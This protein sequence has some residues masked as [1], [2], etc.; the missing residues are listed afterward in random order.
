MKT[1]FEISF[2]VS[3]ILLASCLQTNTN[4]NNSEN[5]DTAS[6]TRST[7]DTK[8][9]PLTDKAVRFLWR[10]DKYD[11][12]FKDTFNTIVIDEDLCKKL[13]EPERAALG[14]V[15][16]FIGS[17]CNW[18][19]EANDDLGNLKCKTLSSLALGYQ[20]SEQ[21]LGFLRQW[22][23]NDNKSLKELEDCPTVPYTASSQSSFDYINLNVKDNKISIKFGANGVN[24]RMGESWNYTETDYFQVANDNIKLIKKEQ[25]KIEREHFDI[26]E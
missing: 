20:C 2:I 6:L 19:G 4:S 25:S 5:A 11:E 16:T 10:E 23:R 18:D 24:M 26:G 1:K 9:I 14:F 12:E 13:S 7:I 8:T 22:F 21:H 15:V 3:I 17:E